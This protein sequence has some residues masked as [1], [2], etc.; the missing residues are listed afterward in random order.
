MPD[1]PS[2]LPDLLSAFHQSESGGGWTKKS[3]ERNAVK[4]CPKCKQKIVLDTIVVDKEGI[5][6]TTAGGKT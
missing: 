1:L 2:S 3:I 6:I 4:K 5:G